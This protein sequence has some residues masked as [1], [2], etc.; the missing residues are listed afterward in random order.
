[1]NSY[2]EEGGVEGGTVRQAKGDVAGADGDV[3]APFTHDVGDGGEGD[4]AGL[5]I[6]ADSHDEGV[7]DDVFQRD[8]DL[9]GAVD[10]LSRDGQTLLSGGGDAVVVHAEGDDG[11]AVLFGEGED[12]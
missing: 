8:A 3:E 9:E 10:D 12:G 2:R 1:M 7:D 5:A 11:G 4:R 6:R